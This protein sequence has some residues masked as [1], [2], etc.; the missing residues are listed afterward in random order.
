MTAG[1][2]AGGETTTSGD[3]P[4][5]GDTTEATTGGELVDQFGF[6]CIELV[7]GEA[8]EGDPF[9]GT[10]RIEVAMLFEPCIQDYFAKHPEMGPD[11]PDDAGGLVFKTWKERLCTEDVADRVDCTVE[12]IDAAVLVGPNGIE[13][14]T[15]IVTYALPEPAELAGRRLL[16][17]PAPLAAYAECDDG[18]APY[19]KLTDLSDVYGIDANDQPLWYLQSFGPTPR[20][21]VGSDDSGCLQLPVMPTP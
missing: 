10:A 4:T 15:L 1:S 5:M 18:L 16:W 11:G 19:A 7:K 2:T 9:A 6:V 3:M 14:T 17:G 21:L 12:S 8:V 13:G 20:G